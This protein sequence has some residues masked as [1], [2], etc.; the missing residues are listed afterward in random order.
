[1]GEWLYGSSAP[2][3]FRSS[4]IGTGHANLPGEG[5]PTAI[6]NVGEPSTVELP[7]VAPSIPG[8]VGD[9]AVAAD[10]VTSILTTLTESIPI[11]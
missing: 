9:A 7:S 6:G 3:R 11:S 8:V 5:A 10:V 2:Q 4:I 1:M